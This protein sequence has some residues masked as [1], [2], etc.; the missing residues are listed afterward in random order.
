MKKKVIRR[1]EKIVKK[2]VSS[3]GALGQIGVPASVID[4]PTNSLPGQPFSTP[5]TTMGHWPSP[6]LWYAQGKAAAKKAYYEY[7]GLLNQYTGAPPDQADRKLQ[8][9]GQM[10]NIIVS[11]IQGVTIGLE[12]EETAAKRA[13]IGD[14]AGV[15]EKEVIA[16]TL[17]KML[18]VIWIHDTAAYSQKFAGLDVQ[19]IE[20]SVTGRL[21]RVNDWEVTEVG[22][23]LLTAQEADTLWIEDPLAAPIDDPAMIN[24]IPGEGADTGGTAP[25]DLEAPA[26]QEDLMSSGE[27]P[28]PENE[29]ANAFSDNTERSVTDTDTT[30]TP[31][32]GGEEIPEEAMQGFLGEPEEDIDMSGP[33]HD[34]KVAWVDFIDQNPEIAAQLLEEATAG[35][36]EVVDEGSEMTSPDE[37]TA[38]ETE[39]TPEEGEEIVE[40]EEEVIPPEEGEEVVEGEEEV[41]PP[42]EGEEV[43]EGEE[44]VVP[45]EEGEDKVVA[46][47][48]IPEGE[49]VVVDED[50]PETVY[51]VGCDKDVTEEEIAACENPD[52]PYKQEEEVVEEKGVQDDKATENKGVQDDEVTEKHFILLDHDDHCD[53]RTHGIKVKEFTGVEGEY[54]LDHTK[55]VS[56]SFDQGI[57]SSADAA[58]WVKKQFAI[59][60]KKNKTAEEIVNEK[61]DNI[62]EVVLK[63]FLQGKESDPEEIEVDFDMIGRVVDNAMNRALG[64]LNERLKELEA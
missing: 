48:D 46:A 25:N 2:E 21:N 15:I 56:Y 12:A 41:V 57:W 47:E 27:V 20:S 13:R 50:E 28:P 7:L 29:A 30:D 14:A 10:N 17:Q 9:A 11:M 31:Q 1:K 3:V 61:I 23:P 63:E 4:T 45:P 18:K 40:G 33:N 52:C 43:V 16:D 53:C 32:E 37:N 44:E 6:N 58:A 49:E 19:A 22:I 60:K 42:E 62:D 36:G 26:G 54:C 35:G 24:Q 59:N 55:L 39:E 5:Q 38:L 51:C 34:L 64:P 8:L